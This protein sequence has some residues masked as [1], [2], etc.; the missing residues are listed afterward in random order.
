MDFYTNI[1]FKVQK[2]RG[3]GSRDQILKFW[4]TQLLN[5][6]EISASAFKFGMDME[7][8]RVLRKD[9]N[10]TTIW[11][12]PGSRDPISKMWDPLVTFE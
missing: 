4:D 9:H 10:T 1:T 8:G 12:W 5:E 2:G 11:A 6:K 3:L 7:D